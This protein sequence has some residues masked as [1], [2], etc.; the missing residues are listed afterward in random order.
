MGIHE[1]KSKEK[2]KRKSLI[3]KSAKKIFLKVGF[4]NA[5]MDMI[6]DESQL[7]KGTLYLYFKSKDDLYVSV[8]LDGI[9]LLEDMLN[10]VD[11]QTNS[12]EDTIIDYAVSY[13]EF[14]EKHPEYFNIMVDISSGDLI[15]LDNVSPDVLE[16]IRFCEQKI[17]LKRV[18]AFQKGID[19]GIFH[20]GFSACYSTTMLWTMITGAITLLRKKGRA[21]ILESIK[22]LDFIKDMTKLFLISQL[23]SVET[24]EKYRTEILENALNQSPH[25]LHQI[26]DNVQMNLKKCKINT[27]INNGSNMLKSLKTI[28]IITISLLVV[29]ACSQKQTSIEGK[30]A[31]LEKI[32]SQISDLQSKAT[33]LENEIGKSGKGSKENALVNV[34]VKEIKPEIFRRFIDL[35]GTVESGKSIMVSPKMSGQIVKIN[36]SN[37]ASVQKGQTLMELDD[38]VLQKGLTELETAYEFA[39][40]VFE[41]QKRLWEQKAGS[42]IQYLQAKNGKESLEKKIATLKQQISW[43]KITAPFAGIVDNISPKIGELA[44]AGMPIIKLTSMSDIKIT[45]EISEA[46]ISSVKAGDMAL[47]NIPEINQKIES[48]ISVISKSIDSKNRTFKI[49]IRLPKVPANLRPNLSCGVS[50]NDITIKDAMVV[51]LSIVQKSG[52]KEFIFT[53]DGPEGNKVKKQFVKTGTS[54]QDKVVILEGLQFSEKVITTGV[55]DVADGQSINIK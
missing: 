51:P 7:S 55:F 21:V 39:N 1:R 2:E 48:K 6:A 16:K 43:C 3:L 37:G 34:E 9:A 19:E 29:V 44:G 32:K 5:S 27:L 52:D 20:A 23:T 41:K 40:T 50:V 49:E 14:S 25:S 31:E 26:E 24:V 36:V 11:E 38:D 10:K 42:E 35:Q 12:I 33:I 22:P 18:W 13:Y 54:Y 30:K 8:L 47:I 17:F 46:Y 45:A 4:A 15:N 28:L 53:V